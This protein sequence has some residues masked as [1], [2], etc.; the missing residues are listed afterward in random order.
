ML[1]TYLNRPAMCLKYLDVERCTVHL[2]CMSAGKQVKLV[3]AQQAAPS[4]AI[5]HLPLQTGSIDK[6]AAF[7][8]THRVKD[9]A[10]ELAARLLEVSLRHHLKAGAGTS[11]LAVPLTPAACKHSSVLGH[12]THTSVAAC[13]LALG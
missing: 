3:G 1:H 11:H 9:M 10:H 7:Y 8:S 13:W 5:P 2:S 6:P 4:A 12:K